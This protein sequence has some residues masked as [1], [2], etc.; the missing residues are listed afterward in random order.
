MVNSTNPAAVVFQVNGLD[1]DIQTITV[2][3]NGGTAEAVTLDAQ[4]RFTRDLSSQAGTVT[5][6]L[7]VKDDANNTASTSATVTI[8]TGGDP[9]ADIAVKSK[10]AAFYAD[11]LHFNWIDNPES[12]T[13]GTPRDYKDSAVVTIS[14]TGTAPLQ[15]LESTL[16]GPFKLANPAA[17]TGLTLGAGKSVD[18][19]V[20]FDRTAYTP[21]AQTVTGVV[22]GALTLR[23]N[24]ADSPIA[25]VN[26]EAFWQQRDEGGWEPNANEIWKMFGFGN[27]IEGLSLNNGGEFSALNFYDVYLPADETEVLSA[28]WRLADG[29]TSAKVTQLAASTSRPGRRSPSTIRDPRARRS[30]S[31]ITIRSRTSPSCHC[32]RTGPS[33]RVRSPTRRFRMPGRATTSSASPSPAF[34]PIPTSIRPG[35]ARRPRP[36]STPA[37]RA[38][39]SRTAT[40]STRAARRCPTATR[41]A[42]SRPWI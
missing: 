1:S 14:N 9:N 34:P 12:V 25:K 30:R 17:F 24:D 20:L 36:S 23:T 19:T 7:V 13:P 4:G 37:I 42:C 29:V 18:V 39:R 15:F 31:P 21:K 38:T 3:F 28:Y 33:P 2:S 40:C 32:G 22:E 11:R 35:P 6:N 5:A 10:D 16:T 26:L 41:S 8:S 27:F